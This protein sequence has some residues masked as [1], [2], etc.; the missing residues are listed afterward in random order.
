MDTH[1]IDVRSWYAI[2]QIYRI[3][4][5]VETWGRSFVVLCPGKFGRYLGSIYVIYTDLSRGHPKRNPTQNGLNSGL[6]IYNKLPR[7]MVSSQLGTSYIPAKEKH[8]PIDQIF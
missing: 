8:K 6:R 7:S 2:G 3:K 4:K 5:N 1:A